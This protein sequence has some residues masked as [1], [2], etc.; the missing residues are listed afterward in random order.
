MVEALKQ[1][2]PNLTGAALPT[3]VEAL[4]EAALMLNKTAAEATLQLDVQVKEG[5]LV[6]TD[7]RNGSIW[8]KARS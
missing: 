1:L 7:T 3:T 5:K 2:A 6:R 8:R 4:C